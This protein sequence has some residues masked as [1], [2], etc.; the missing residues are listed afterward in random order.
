MIF[1]T[2]RLARVASSTVRQIPRGSVSISLHNV[3]SFAFFVLCNLQ[4][5]LLISFLLGF[6]MFVVYSLRD[7]FLCCSPWDWPP[8]FSRNTQYDVRRRRLLVCWM[9]RELTKPARIAHTQHVPMQSERG[10]LDFREDATD[11]IA[12]LWLVVIG[13]FHVR[14]APLTVLSAALCTGHCLFPSRGVGDQNWQRLLRLLGCAGC[15]RDPRSVGG[16]RAQPAQS[17][18]HAG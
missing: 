10:L 4:Y 2:R 1:S 14:K 16:G 17:A 15:R 5:S 6:H 7:I 13:A 8:C 18:A 11:R 12:P 3:F 9:F